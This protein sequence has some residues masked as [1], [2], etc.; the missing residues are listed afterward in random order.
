MISHLAKIVL[1]LAIQIQ[2]IP[3][4]TFHEQRRA[5]FVHQRFQAE[6]LPAELDAVG[7]VYARLPGRGDALPVVVVAHLDTVF[8]DTVDMTVSR[9]PDRISAPGIGDNSLGVAS[10]FGLVWHVRQNNNDLPG[11]IWLVADVGEEGLGDLRGMRAVV[12]RFNDKVSAYIIVEGMALGQVY[13]RGLGIR[14]YRISAHTPGGHSWTDFGSPS[15]NHELAVLIKHLTDIT[16]PSI[17]RTSLNVGVISG[18]VSVNTIAGN[19]QLE[20]DLRSEN[21]KTLDDLVNQVLDLVRA[22]NR[23]NVAM[24]A[25]LIGSRP[26]GELPGDHPLVR[27]AAECLQKRG[28]TAQFHASSTDANIPLSKGFPVVG[29]GITN[30]AGAHTTGEYILTAPIA[31]GLEILADLVKKA[32]ALAEG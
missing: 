28:M 17:P 12:D 22:A 7:N 26:S 3:A 1:D 10:L 21:Q 9:Q 15:A 18:G 31:Q 32:F 29:V 8:P 24:T 4:P 16:L 19:A 5:D 6:G 20:L 30:G 13:H 2:Q 11:D 27:A 25:E 23:Q 14:R